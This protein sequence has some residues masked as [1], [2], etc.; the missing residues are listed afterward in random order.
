MADENQNQ[1]APDFT[2]TDSQ[3]RGQGGEVT[4]PNDEFQNPKEIRDPKPEEGCPR[5]WP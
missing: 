3:G 5:A 4:N 1:V 2:A